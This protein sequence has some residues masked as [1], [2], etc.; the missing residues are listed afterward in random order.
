MQNGRIYRKGHSW[1][2]D[3]AVKELRDGVPKWAKRSK[4]LAPVCDDYRTPASVKHLAAEHLAP[5]NARQTKPE[6]TDTVEHFI[7]NTYLLHCKANL[8]ASTHGG[9]VY[10]FKALKPHLGDERLRDFGPVEGERLL[11]DF[12][13]EKQRPNTMLK[14]AKGF[15]SGAFRYAVRTGTIRFNPMR[16]TM[17]PKNGKPMADTYAYTL[18]EIQAM[19][20]VLPEPSRTVVLVAALTGLR[21]SEIRGLKWTDLEGDSLHVR[22]S[23]W[24]THVS[25][26][27]TVASAGTVPLLPDVVEALQAHRKTSTSEYIFAGGT[28]KPL[29]LANVTRRDIAPTLEAKNIPWHGWHG[30]RRG[31]ASNLHELGVPDQVIQGI[32]RHADVQV[33]QRHYIKTRPA[34]S[35]RAMRKLG[36]A[37]RRVR[38]TVRK[39]KRT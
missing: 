25:E 7:Q 2:L 34:A 32:L 17:L 27:K 14:N 18:S 8:R 33:T 29:V 22:R 4:K 1:I 21:M 20:K 37:F 36:R 3:Y 15:L 39:N 11:N 19:L 26:T 13:A 30:F 6:S 10:L 9:Y 35:D 24:R 16:E 38:K 31:L 23:V 28:G 12:A 5:Q